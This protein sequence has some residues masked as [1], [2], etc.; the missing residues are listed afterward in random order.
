L[1]KDERLAMVFL[2]PFERGGESTSGRS[3]PLNDKGLSR[4]GVYAALWNRHQSG[5]TQPT[6]GARSQAYLGLQAQ[7]LIA[8]ASARNRL[9]RIDEYLDYDGE[10]EFSSAPIASYPASLAVRDLSRSVWG[11]LLDMMDAAAPIPRFLASLEDLIEKRPDIPGADPEVALAHTKKIFGLCLN[12]NRLVMSGAA[13]GS[14][15]R[16]ASG[17]HGGGSGKH[18]PGYVNLAPSLYRRHAAENIPWAGPVDLV[19]INRDLEDHGADAERAGDAPTERERPILALYDPTAL[20]GAIARAR[21]A[22]RIR[23][24]LAQRFSWDLAQPTPQQLESLLGVLQLHW[25]TYLEDPSR[26]LH[27]KNAQLALIVEVMLMFGKSIDGARSLTLRRSDTAAVREFALLI[28][29]SDSGGMSVRGWRLPLIEPDYRTALP[30][31]Q[32]PHA[33]LRAK[34]RSFRDRYELGK[35][36][37]EYCR[38]EGRRANNPVFTFQCE[39]VSN[40][41]QALSHSV[42]ALDGLTILRI[43]RVLETTVFNQTGDWAMAWH[44]AGD[45]AKRNEPRMFY[46]AFPVT[47]VAAAHD[48]ALDATMIR[49]GRSDIATGGAPADYRQA[50]PA[51]LFAGPRFVVEMKSLSRLIANLRNGLGGFLPR[52]AGIEDRIE[53]HNLYT[54]YTWLVQSLN[55]GLRAVN[56]P[57]EIIE[58]CRRTYTGSPIAVTLAD[59]ETEFLDRARPVMPTHCVAEQLDAYRRHARMLADSSDMSRS[60]SAAEQAIPQLFVLTDARAPR[61]LTRGWIEEALSKLGFPFP[62]N[63]SRAF[64]RTELVMRGCHPEEVDAFMGHANSGERPFAA[65]ATFD[66][67]RHFVSIDDGL[68]LINRDLRLVPLSSRLLP[69]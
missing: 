32:L 69:R 20:K 14:R 56:D 39:T 8:L 35:R 48:R 57:S 44:V 50:S 68:R 52:K 16:V 42:E 37:L 12:S 7:L 21:T 51:P 34:S 22:E 65:H 45:E 40:H 38:L 6:G 53:Y 13:T 5:D 41:F 33:R 27:K 31:G 60:P 17:R 43:Q 23:Q 24:S 2:R 18:L 55:T 61:I 9:T 4:H 15:R 11:P 19:C 49:A 63:F 28:D 46:A 3:H 26:S 62:G 10:R 25:N 59:K 54:L 64:L 30:K 1:S 36:I 58:Q 29:E 66:Y 47:A 67:A